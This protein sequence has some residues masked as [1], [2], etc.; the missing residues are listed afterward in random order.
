[1]FKM[2]DK[3]IALLQYLIAALIIAM[4]VLQSC[5]KSTVK[6]SE[7]NPNPGETSTLKLVPDSMFRE[8][9]K[10]NVCPNAFD[11]TGKL[12]DINSSEVKNFTGT[13]IIDTV[14]ISRPF[15]SSLR[16]IE[17]FTKMTK[18]IVQ[19]GPIDSLVLRKT[20][21]LD[22]L[23]LLGTR[24]LQY[25]D[26]SGL[27]SMRY[28]KATYLPVLSLDLSNLPALEYVT[29]QNMGRVNELKVENDGNLRHLMTYALTGLKSV[30]L[31]TN[32]ELQRLFLDYAPSVNAVDVTHNPKLI[33]ILIRNTAI[34][35]SVDLSKNI[36][37][38]YVNFDETGIDT[39]DVSHNPELFALTMLW[40]PVRN[41]SLLANPKL[42]LLWLDGCTQLKNVDLRAQTKFEFWFVPASKWSGL[43]DG[44]VYEKFK[45]GISSP[46]QTA[47]CNTFSPATR[48]GV[49]GATTNLFGGLRLPVYPDAGAL[50][51]QQVKV[52]DATKDNYSLVMSRR[53]IGGSPM[54][55][56][57]YAA[58]KTTIL[59]N[60]YDPLNFRCN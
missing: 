18:L 6:P 43:S 25:V 60:D 15:V 57:V 35:K 36:N 20:M 26:V 30:N 46:V 22:S 58:D 48:A 16:G 32:P 14:N 23:K 49:G 21:A 29:L 24:E 9:L 55:V 54:L 50:S 7:E 11:K 31:S 4:L 27:T 1:M 51:L 52:Q 45:D 3:Q 2:K 28:I 37:L 17:Y 40:T 5:S 10:A 12:L 33:N 38:R 41:I 34:L 42:Q 47:D 19:N 53:V 56:T 44:D 39:I 13:M 8:Y 59:C